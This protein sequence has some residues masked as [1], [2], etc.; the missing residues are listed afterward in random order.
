MR[1]KSATIKD[2]KRFTDLTVQGIP[3][4]A[5]LI[6]LAGPNGCGKSSFFD[7]LHTWR[8]A[9]SGRGPKWDSAYHK[10]SSSQELGDSSWH[11]HVRIQFYDD[12]PN[13]MRNNRKIFYM[14]SAYRNDPEFQT[15]TLTRQGDPLDQVPVDRMIDN[16]AAIRRNYQKLVSKVFEDL[17]EQGE[18][19]MTFAKYRKESIG[20]IRDALRQLFPDLKLNSLGNP[21]NDGTFRFTK[22]VSQ[23]FDIKN[24]SGGEKAVFDLILDLVVAKHSYDDTIFCID[25]PEGHLNARLQ[26]GLLQVLYDLIPENCQLMLATHSIGMMRRARDIEVNNPGSVVFLDFG[27]RDFDQPQVIEPTKPGRTFWKAAY[28]VALNDLAELVAPE[29]IVICEGEPKNRNAGQSYSHDARC[30]DIIFKT[31]FPETQFVPGGNASEVEM[32][33]R[34][35]AYALAVLVQGA[36]VMKLIDR[37]DRSLE[38]VAELRKKGVRVLSRRNLESYLFGDEVLEALAKSVDKE[39]KTEALLAK[40]ESILSTRPNDASDDIKPASGEIYV[41]CKKILELP[42]PG[43]DS[44]SFM[45]DT[46]ARLVEPGMVVYEELKR[47]IF[48]QEASADEPMPSP[49][50][51][52]GQRRSELK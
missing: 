10:K 1:F 21:L 52:P 30:Y 41:A 51:S 15:S 47:D 43:N 23:G 35:I 45:R 26:A 44:K 4:T 20:D 38:E 5:R 31:E 11:H 2:F 40:K 39:D 28:N 36:E 17:Y 9:M 50:P 19:S 13:D 7:A 18:G 29:Q 14:R 16:D 34:G 46:L 25:E 3:E 24:L 37:D 27:N 49:H 48:G 33:K 8:E 42:N 6:M 12:L 32:D 22:G